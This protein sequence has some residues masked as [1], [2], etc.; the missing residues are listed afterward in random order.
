MII[1]KMNAFGLV[2]NSAVSLAI[3][4]MH[5]RHEEQPLLAFARHPRARGGARRRR[6]WPLDDIRA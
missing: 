4:K 6:F 1:L 2:D 5:T 3:I